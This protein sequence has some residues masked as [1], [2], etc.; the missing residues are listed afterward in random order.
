[1]LPREAKWLT[2]LVLKNYQP[3][4][5]DAQ[6][7]YRCC[8]PALPM[9]YKVQE[10]FVAALNFVRQSRGAM[11]PNSL[12]RRPMKDAIF[13][14]LKP[15]IGIKVGRQHWLKGRSIK[16]CLDLGHGRMSVES[17]IDGEYCQIHVAIRNGHAQIQIFSKSGKDSTEDRCRLQRYYR[18]DF[19]LIIAD[20]RSAPLSHHSASVNPLVIFD[21]IAYWKA[22]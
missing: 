14:S 16:H 11:L 19:D 4:A 18:T 22:N 7:I 8:H 21:K 20:S 1:M 6:L 10:D 5:L 2:R 9:V 12:K 15:Q 13:A 17:K 3:L